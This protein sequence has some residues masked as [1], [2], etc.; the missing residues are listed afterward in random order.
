MDRGD[1]VAP[2]GRGPAACRARARARHHGAQEGGARAGAGAREP[3]ALERRARPVRVRRLA[4]PQGAADP[5]LRVRADAGRE[6]RRGAGRGGTDV[7]GPRAPRGRP[8]E[9]DDRRP[10]RL[11]A[12]RDAGPEAA[13]TVDLGEM[14]R[15]GPAHA[16]SADRGDAAP[17]SRCT[18]RFPTVDGSPGSVR[19]AVPQPDRATRSSSAATSHRW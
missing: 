13:C 19:A 17:G 4:R 11:L 16:R 7:P 10:A 12:R 5:A 9:G 1:D 3:R 8:D 14:P 6:V 18:G 2:R 15:H